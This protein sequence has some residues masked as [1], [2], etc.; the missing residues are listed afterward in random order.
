MY[1]VQVDVQK[2][3]DKDNLIFIWLSKTILYI[4]RINY[5]ISKRMRHKETTKILK[6]ALKYVVIHKLTNKATI[7][8]FKTQVATYINVSTRT[9]LRGLPYESVNYKVYLITNVVL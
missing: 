8:R 5:Q 2:I 4:C 7:F 6:R 9:L 1:I 3:G